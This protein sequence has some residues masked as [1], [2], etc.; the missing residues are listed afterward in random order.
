MEVRVKTFNTTTTTF[1]L[2]RSLALEHTRSRSLA[3]DPRYRILR[4][5]KM[6]A[7][8]SVQVSNTS[9]SETQFN[10]TTVVSS[11]APVQSDGKARVARF[12]AG[13]EGVEKGKDNGNGN[14]AGGA[15]ARAAVRAGG[16]AM[17]TETTLA[18]DGSAGRHLDQVPP[19]LAAARADTLHRKLTRL[20]VSSKRS[21]C[22]F[23]VGTYWRRR[24]SA[25][26]PSLV[27]NVSVL[28]LSQPDHRLS[29]R[30]ARY[31]ST[32]T[33]CRQERALCY[34]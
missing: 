30:R 2:S 13:P 23:V 5:S 22:A 33:K 32:R 1:S 12:A 27:F 4:A 26:I 7:E 16:G 28:T 29:Q 18:T 9:S 11:S 6:A 20:R 25:D 10:H 31:R 14:G 34:N 3:L 19:M 8:A 17:E 24:A 15:S 21:L